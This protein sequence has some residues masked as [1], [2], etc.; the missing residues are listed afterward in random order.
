MNPQNPKT[1]EHGSAAPTQSPATER[2]IAINLLAGP[3]GQTP[4]PIYVDQ[5]GSLINR[6]HPGVPLEVLG[7]T[8][9][10][11]STVVELDFSDVWRQPELAAGKYAVLVFPDMV[12]RA[13][14]FLTQ[15]AAAVTAR[16]A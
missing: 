7:F 9:R 13:S 11:D 3:D 14:I 1:A 10:F 2:V 8:S 15:S 5:V 16:H 12:I 6:E 4:P